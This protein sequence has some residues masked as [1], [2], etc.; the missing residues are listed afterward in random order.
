MCTKVLV[1]LMSCGFLLLGGCQG[2]QFQV[3]KT[4][5][6]KTVQSTDAPASAAATDAPA[7][8]S[9]NEAATVQNGSL[10]AATIPVAIGGAFLTCSLGSSSPDGKDVQCLSKLDGKPVD[11][12]LSSIY[13]VDKDSNW[14][15]LAFQHA[16]VGVYTLKAPTLVGDSFALVLKDTKGATA[17]VMMGEGALAYPDIV[18]DGQFTAVP[19]SSLLNVGY[20]TPDD[21]GPWKVKASSVPQ[22]NCMF[23]FLKF[24]MESG[25]HYMELDS[26]CTKEKSSAKATDW[27]SLL[28]TNLAA[29]Q[30]LTTKPRHVYAISFKYRRS[31]AADISA[32]SAQNLQQLS[33]SWNG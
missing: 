14:V 7:P 19:I 5:D 25:R 26:L 3:G 29:Y 17:P 21:N 12:D 30:T 15:S 23:P 4:K 32:A 10:P 18:K 33:V 2:S 31:L 20:P 11:V 16:S 22:S 13:A 27:N 6:G 8:A 24:A 9:A 28:A 1:P